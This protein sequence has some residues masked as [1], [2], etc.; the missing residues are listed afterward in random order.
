[1]TT[2]RLPMGLHGLIPVYIW[3]MLIELYVLHKKKNKTL[4]CKSDV[5][6]TDSK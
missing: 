2:G 5:F 3:A 1:M 4:I 6:Y